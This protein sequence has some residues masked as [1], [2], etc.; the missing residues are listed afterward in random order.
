[1]KQ[2]NRPFTAPELLKQLMPLIREIESNL[3]FHGY[4][5]GTAEWEKMFK[6]QWMFYR[7]FGN[8]NF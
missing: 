2:K 1:M 6:H 5:K 4:T 7:K 3:K 8:F